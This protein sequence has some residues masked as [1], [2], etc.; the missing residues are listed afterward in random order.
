MPNGI[1]VYAYAI[2]RECVDAP[3]LVRLV[4]AKYPVSRSV[5]LKWADLGRYRVSSIWKYSLDPPLRNPGIKTVDLDQPLW[6][7]RNDP[8]LAVSDKPSLEN[9]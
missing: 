1:L 7:L 4:T 5:P 3:A 8:T 9:V 6:R 2:Y